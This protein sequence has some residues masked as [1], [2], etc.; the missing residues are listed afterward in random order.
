VTEDGEIFSDEDEGVMP[1]GEKSALICV[2]NVNGEKWG[3]TGD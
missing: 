2:G 3:M 1:V